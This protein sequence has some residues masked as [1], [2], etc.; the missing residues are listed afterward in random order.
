MLS[1]QRS[2]RANDVYKVQHI[3]NAYFALARTRIYVRTVRARLRCAAAFLDSAL[4]AECFRGVATPQP[5]QLCLA[6]E[7]D[8]ENAIFSSHHSSEGKILDLNRRRISN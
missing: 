1:V 6:G 5:P 4:V 8:L 3:R 2:R 7:S